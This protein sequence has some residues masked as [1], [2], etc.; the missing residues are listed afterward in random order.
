[1]DIEAKGGPV[2]GI[3]YHDRVFDA[4]PLE[5]T[6]KVNNDT[7]HVLYLTQTIANVDRSVLDNT[8]IIVFHE[9]FHNVNHLYIENFG[10]GPVNNPSLSFR[11]EDAKSYSGPHPASYYV[12]NTPNHIQLTSF[13]EEINVDIKDAINKSALKA[14]PLVG[15]FGVFVFEDAQR[16]QHAL[17]FQTRV[18]RTPPGPGAAPP[19]G[20]TYDLYLKAGQ[21]NVT[22]TTSVD[23]TFPP[24]TS[25]EFALRVLTD[26][27]AS[28]DVAF[29]FQSTTGEV[30][31]GERTQ[32][33]LFQPR[34]GPSAK[35]DRMHYIAVSRTLLANVQNGSL[36]TKI[37]Y[38]PDN[39][40]HI[41]VHVENAF[42][43]LPEDEKLK[44]EVGI[45][46]TIAKF[47]KITDKVYLAFYDPSGHFWTSGEISIAW[48]NRAR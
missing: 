8:P 3:Y 22:A 40:R 18:S 1:L 48:I 4:A 10:W 24:K 30:L 44:T 36:V 37:A 41:T 25:G 15:V 19:K 26:R 43:S 35:L 20:M 39:H 42:R 17:K 27:S 33:R 2:C 13:N 12:D 28:F 32:L 5:L 6:V 29:S 34:I 11:V 16:K 7:S 31:P 47:L 23:E 21:S 14:A 9:E 38:N 45:A 46:S